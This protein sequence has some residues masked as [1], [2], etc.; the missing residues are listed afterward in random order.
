MP[1][2]GVDVTP[3]VAKYRPSARDKVVLTSSVLA[4]DNERR[5]GLEPV[6]LDRELELRV[7]EID[8]ADEH[9]PLAHR[10]LRDRTRDAVRA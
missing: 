8:P 10:V 1:R 7:S 3:D 6:H 4:K 9:V 2:H 5:V